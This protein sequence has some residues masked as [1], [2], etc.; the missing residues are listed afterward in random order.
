MSPNEAADESQRAREAGT[1]AGE[2][3]DESFAIKA[4]SPAA[5]SRLK[6]IRE[7]LEI[8]DRAEYGRRR[9]AVAQALKL[10]ER[11]VD[12][13]VRQGRRD[14]IASLVRR[15]RSDRGATESAK[16]G[17]SLLSK[18]IERGIGAVAG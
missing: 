18:P 10:S 4:S 8:A 5:A 3:R 12:R 14:G 1:G 13:L 7:L 17:K 2:S 6:W 16:H 15:G 9:E 11:S